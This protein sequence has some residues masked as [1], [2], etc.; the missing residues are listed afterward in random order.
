MLGKLFVNGVYTLLGEEGS[1]GCKMGA[2]NYSNDEMSIG[3]MGLMGTSDNTS[4]SHLIHPH[5][6]LLNNDRP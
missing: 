3:H 4:Y 2:Y 5:M 1:D 6:S